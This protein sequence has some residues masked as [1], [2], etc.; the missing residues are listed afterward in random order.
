M[1]DRG[2][3]QIIAE[4]LPLGPDEWIS[5]RT[6]FAHDILIRLDRAGYAILRRNPMSNP[7]MRIDET[8]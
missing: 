8:R 1:D 3:L 7:A 5:D 2:P 6:D 4:M